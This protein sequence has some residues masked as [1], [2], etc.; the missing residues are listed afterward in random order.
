MCTAFVKST[1]HRSSGK[2]T[3]NHA[4]LKQSTESIMFV[5][6]IYNFSKLAND[7]WVY[8][9]F[10]FVLFKQTEHITLFPLIK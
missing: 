8:F 9:V 3:K 7:L 1:I 4:Q 6:I 10:F 2:Q 5:S